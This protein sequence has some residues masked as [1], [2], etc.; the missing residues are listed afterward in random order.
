MYLIEK[1]QKDRAGM[2]G[3]KKKRRYS[4]HE[5]DISAEKDFQIQSSWISQEDEHRGRKK[6]TGRQT[7]ERK[8][9]IICI[10]QI[11]KLP[12]PERPHIFLRMTAAAVKGAGHPQTLCTEK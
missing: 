12:K 9:S 7:C 5:N 8:K 6:G 3:I 1:K 4:D 11:P 2:C 10:R